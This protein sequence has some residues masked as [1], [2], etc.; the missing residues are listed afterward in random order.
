MNQI[1]EARIKD[2][3][4]ESGVY[5][6]AGESAERLKHMQQLALDLIKAIELE[7]SGIRDG[8]GGWY[9]AHPVMDIADALAELVVAHF[10]A[11]YPFG[12]CPDCRVE[13]PNREDWPYTNAGKTHR[14]YC[15]EHKTSWVGGVNLMSTWQGET[16]EEQRA[17]W[18]RIGLDNYRDVE[19]A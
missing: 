3:Q 13:F 6:A 8:D 17:A 7:R 15:T 18:D 10:R 11:P 12:S 5:P 1:A 19:P 2:W 16:E 9:G 14:F 4:Y